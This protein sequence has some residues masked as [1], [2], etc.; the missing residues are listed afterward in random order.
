M[1][2]KI[3]HYTK[4]YRNNHLHIKYWVVDIIC[5][6]L[7]LFTNGSIRAFLYRKA[8][9]NIGQGT[10]IMGS[11]ELLSGNPHFYSNLTIG[12]NTLFSSHVTINLDGKVV[13][14]DN[15]TIGPFVRIYTATHEIGP[16]NNRCVRYPVAKAVIVEEGCWIALGATILP[17]VRIYHGSVVAAGAVV[18][19]DVPP[20]SLV[21]GVPGK[22]VKT[23]TSEDKDYFNTLN[24]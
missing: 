4:E 3:L 17:G 6:I 1:V 9:F 2:K 18:T 20:N 14:G 8:G 19:K 13:I 5:K 15:V 10:Y 12:S 21:S 23:L 16:S 24:I 7:P 22:V 11:I